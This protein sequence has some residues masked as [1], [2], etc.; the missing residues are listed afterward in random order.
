MSN[1]LFSLD[2]CCSGMAQN[3]TCVTS[4]V[5]L[6]HGV[7][8]AGEARSDKPVVQYDFAQYCHHNAV[9]TTCKS[10]TINR[11]VQYIKNTI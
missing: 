4:R 6:V 3:Q 8:G 11:A 5:P 10:R 1:K 9:E 2:I 7:P